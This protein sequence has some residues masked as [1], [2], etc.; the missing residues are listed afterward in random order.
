[1]DDP[2]MYGESDGN[3]PTFGDSGLGETGEPESD[4]NVGINEDTG[5]RV[6]RWPGN[7]TYDGLTW[8]RV[9]PK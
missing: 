9:E 8:D 3:S 6:E 7:R 5:N 4:W 2:T 1:M